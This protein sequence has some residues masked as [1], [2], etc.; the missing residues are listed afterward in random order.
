M[1]QYKFYIMFAGMMVVGLMATFIVTQ[2]YYPVALVGNNFVSERTF[3]MEYR[4]ASLY[5]ENLLKAYDPLSKEQ[6]K[7][8]DPKEMEAGAMDQ[9]VENAL[10][11]DGAE[12]EVGGD[13]D[14]LI[15]NKLGKYSDDTDLAKAGLTLYGL[16]KKSFWDEILIPQATKEVLQGRL[17][18]KGQNI[19]DWLVSTKK[20]ARVIIFSPQ[21]RWDG[22]QVQL[23]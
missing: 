22:A 7:A 11:K 8:A 18:L 14:T 2:G 17:Y 9:L 12:R 4:A 5:Y 16:D 19:D 23:K 10:I 6:D 21:L 3:A 20:A 1:A 13:L 15:Q